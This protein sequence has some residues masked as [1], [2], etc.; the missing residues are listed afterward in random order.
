M[1]GIVGI[2]SKGHDLKKEIVSG[3]LENALTKMHRRGPD[4]K[5][6]SLVHK[7]YAT[8]FVRL[9]IRDLSENGMQPMKTDCMNF[10]ISFN[11]EIYNTALLLQNLEKFNIEFKS[12]TDTEI[13][14]YHFKY[15]GFKKTINI[16]DGIFA[17]ALYDKKK[18]TL[19][20][21]RDRAGVKPLY[22]YDDNKQIIYSS[23]YNQVVNNP[24]VK[25]N[26]VCKDGL[27]VYFKL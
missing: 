25:N 13:I 21:S 8:G 26:K 12:T 18:N 6:A 3:F 2:Y 20:L 19:Y 7:Y 23:N 11:G 9:A 10:T 14:L 24:F 27:S 17:I 4:S 22:I 15:F 5:R 16:L 1:C